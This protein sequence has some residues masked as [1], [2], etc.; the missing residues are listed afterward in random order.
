MQN[1]TKTD[2]GSVS[3]SYDKYLNSDK[4]YHSQII[5]PNLFR[6]IG[7]VKG[8]SL[9]DIACGQGQISDELHRMGAAVEAFDAGKELINIAIKNNRNINYKVANAEDFAGEYFDKNS[10]KYQSFDVIICVLALQNIEN[11]KKVIDNIKVVSNKDTRIFFVINHPSFRI[12]KYSSWVYDMVGKEDVQI[13]RVEKYMSEDK[14]KLDMTPGVRKENEKEYTYSYHRPLQYYF[15][16]LSKNDMAVI[17]LEEWISNRESS[18]KHSVRENIARK[19]FPLFMCLEIK[20][21]V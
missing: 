12:P 15:K 10:N 7:P 8:K 3:E 13:R 19:E 14:I 2:W 1:K 18:G 20:N 11:F 21:S 16:I 17:R 6:M 9:L 4:N 5:I